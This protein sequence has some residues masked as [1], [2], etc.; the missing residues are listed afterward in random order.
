MVTGDLTNESLLHETK[1]PDTI[2]N[3]PTA[4]VVKI[5]GQSLLI[6]A[7]RFS[8]LDELKQCIPHHK[9]IIGTGAGTRLVMLTASELILGCNRCLKCI[10]DIRQHAERPDAA[11]FVGR[12]RIPLSN[13]SSFHNFRFILLSG[14]L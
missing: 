14:R 9:M 12:S 13:Q 2:Q 8:T 7:V 4:N 10:G 11:L 1:K 3:L 5:G 6:A